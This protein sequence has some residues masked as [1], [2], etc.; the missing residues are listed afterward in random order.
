MAGNQLKG[1]LFKAKVK[2]STLLE[3][4]VSMVLIVVVFTLALT[5]YSNV[6][7]LSLS[8]RKLRAHAVISALA[9]RADSGSSASSETFTEGDLRVEQQASLYQGKAGL[10]QVSLT[11]FDE[12]GIALDSV[13]KIRALTETGTP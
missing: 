5:I 13:K 6:L 9:L 1:T 12:A 11:A 3:V 7:K 10:Q 8:V 4:V 2:A